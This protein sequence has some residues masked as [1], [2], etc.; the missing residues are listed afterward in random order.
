MGNRVASITIFADF[1]YANYSSTRMGK[2]TVLLRIKNNHFGVFTRRRQKVWT[3]PE[4]D[5]SG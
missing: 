4:R 1:R 3:I 2:Q 5:S